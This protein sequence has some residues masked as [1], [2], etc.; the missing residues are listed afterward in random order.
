VRSTPRRR[1]PAIATILLGTVL[2]QGLVVAISPLLTRLYTPAD[3]GTLAVVTAVAS[4]LGAGATLGTDRALVVAH[5]TATTSALVALGLLSTLVVGVGTTGVA[6]VLRGDAARWFTAPALEDLWWTVP[7]T[8]VAVG[9]QRIASAV[10]ARRQQH[11]SIAVRNAC[12]G[13]GQSVWNLTMAAAGPVGLVGGL[14]VGRIAAVLG[15]VRSR[16]GDGERITPRA[17]SAAARHHRRFLVITPWSSMLNVVGQQAPGLLIAALHGSVAAGFV[18]LTMRVLGAPVGM[19]ADA[20][21]QYAAG[22]FGL[23]IR[24]ADPVRGLLVR[25]VVRL[26]LAGAVAAVVVVLLGPAVFSTVFGPEWAV[27]GT[28]A[29]VLVPAFAIQVA[30]S[31]VTQVLSMLQRQGAQLA[32]DGARLALSASAVLVPSLLGAPMLVVLL[33]LASAMA[34]SYAAV[35]LMVLR[36]ARI[37]DRGASGRRATRRRREYD[38]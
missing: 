26:A 21:A 1:L 34:I 5:D 22:A 31:P 20:T 4:I 7:V 18:A 23:R 25:L 6:W 14:A 10:L 35:L 2:G 16:R 15:M 36:A 12:Q 13:I 24:S 38:M 27:S 8:V 30:E 19:V 28:Y 32:W 29:Q 9:A 33:S 17:L 37:H 11:R 3:F